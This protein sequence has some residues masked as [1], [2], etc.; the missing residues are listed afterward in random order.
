MTDESEAAFAERVEA[1]LD[2]TF[3]QGSWQAQTVLEDT[4]RRPDYWVDLG[5]VAVAVEVDNDFEGA[6]AGV[7][8]A[9]LYAAHAP[10][11]WPL[12]VIPADHGDQPELELLQE[13][14]PVAVIEL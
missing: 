10:N 9:L 7:G 4:R 13:R 12:V 11:V 2:E 6:V 8:Q 5:C 14:A 1:W 3:G